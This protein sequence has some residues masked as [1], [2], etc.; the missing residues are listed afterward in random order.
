MPTR[1]P[2][3]NIIP[4]I[5]CLFTALFTGR[6]PVRFSGWQLGMRDGDGAT[7]IRLSLTYQPRSGDAIAHDFVIQG[8][9]AD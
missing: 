3:S 7:Q 5:S 2:V 4:L 1:S 8:V 9:R 6:W